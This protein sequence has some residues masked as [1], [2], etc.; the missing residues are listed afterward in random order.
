MSGA[1]EHRE[2]EY[3]FRIPDDL[4]LDVIEILG[5]TGMVVTPRSHRS[6]S[7]IY[8]DTTDLNLLRWGIT[9]RRRVGGGDDGWHLKIP[10]SGDAGQR[11]EIRVER[12]DATVPFEL[13]SII[14]PLLRRRELVPMAQVRTERTP[15][16]VSAPD[17][18]E[19][20][21]VVDDRVTVGQP[22]SDAYS[23]FRE[24][25]VELLQHSEAAYGA[26]EA[27]RTQFTSAG[28]MSSSLS[29]AARALGRRAGDPPDVPE[30]P[31]PPVDG[32]AIDALQAIFSRYV[33]D[34][35]TAD[36]GVRRRSPDS[37]HRMRVACRRLR[38]TLK[39]FESLLD[40]ETTGFLR[41]ELA[42]LATE[43][44]QVRDTE[45]QRAFLTDRIVDAPARDF[46]TEE[47]D[48]RLRAAYS[49]ALAALRS[50]RHDFLIE[51]LILLV[52]EPPVT[53]AAFEGAGQ[54]LQACAR[55]PW[56]RLRR[57]VQHADGSPQSWHRVRLKA[58]QARYAVEA[59]APILGDDYTKLGASLAWVT[60]TL[61]SRQDAHVSILTLEELAS[62][63]PGS[64]AF[65]LG[66]QAAKCEVTGD[67]DVR[68]FLDRWPTLLDQAAGMGLD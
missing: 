12:S 30:L 6:M 43:L 41:E 14:S 68:A 40:T 59:I 54:T 51:D 21:E 24:A 58:K 65:E 37:V 26:A 27:L 10:T 45:V 62:R 60:D 17:G 32:S 67:E 39:T 25:E 38:A 9:L 23:A 34:L 56:K 57:S 50:D 4:P 63:A 47:L 29:K 61:G 5:A 52:S 1:V 42:W 53:A 11:D 49:S 46:V 22:Q 31:Y 7:A 28:A 33:R 64:I 44:G 8:Y 16:V 3:K 55:T 19:L 13:A 18:T 2:V 48:Q 35:L 15:F 20:V 66:W 36:V